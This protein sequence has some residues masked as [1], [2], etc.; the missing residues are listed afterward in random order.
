MQRQAVLEIGDLNIRLLNRASLVN[1]KEC[2]ATKIESVGARSGED[3]CPKY[4]TVRVSV[5]R[6]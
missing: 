5:C 6:W 4:V 3:T 2:C 1:V